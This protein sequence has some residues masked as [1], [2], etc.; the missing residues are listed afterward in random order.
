MSSSYLS[1]LLKFQVLE[2]G[3][4]QTCSTVSFAFHDGKLYLNR[5]C[6]LKLEF[7][8][9]ERRISLSQII[10]MPCQIVDFHQLIVLLS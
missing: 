7:L 9:A 3:E 1:P 5:N 6:R 8:Q 2:R 4:G 10:C